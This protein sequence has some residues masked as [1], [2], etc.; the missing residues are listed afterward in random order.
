MTT[1]GDVPA[2]EPEE[3]LPHFRAGSGEPL[4]LLHDIGGQFGV[5][6]PVIGALTAAR[7]VVAP[8]L[9][10]F[11]DAPSLIAPARPDI[12]GLTDAIET[13]IDRL[14][15]GSPHLG[16]IG[17]GGWVALELA[18]RGRASSVT[19]VSP[20][21]AWSR[22]GALY[23]RASL[24][25]AVAALKVLDRRLER[26]TASGLGRRILLGQA[27]AHPDRL[28]PEIATLAARNLAVS[29]GL[30][31]TLALT[32]RERLL[33]GA[34]I[35][36]PVTIAWGSRDRLYFPGQARRVLAMIPQARLVTLEDCGHIPTFDD[37]DQVTKVLLAGS[38]STSV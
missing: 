18:R 36:V 20:A 23:V 1:R 25:G 24:G 13:F 11:A 8:N 21:G 3:P 5:W 32:S 16:G 10:G 7:D 38:E 26:L 28:A 34:G 14:E 17:V 27:M 2:D 29:P 15:L 4:V 22:A 6:A 30:L 37:P 9:P 33:S 31:Q 35:T 19:A 12:A